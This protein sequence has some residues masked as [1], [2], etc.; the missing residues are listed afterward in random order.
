[1]IAR[2]DDALS[3]P[4]GEICSTRWST[5]RP[6]PSRTWAQTLREK[7]RPHPWATPSGSVHGC[8]VI[9]GG[10]GGGKT[11]RSRSGKR[12]AE[13]RRQQRRKRRARF[14]FGVRTDLRNRAVQAF[15]AM[16][17]LSSGYWV[18]SDPPV[19]GLCSALEF[20]ARLILGFITSRCHFAAFLLVTCSMV[21]HSC[22][23]LKKRSSRLLGFWPMILH[24]RE[25][26]QRVALIGGPEFV[27]R[28]FASACL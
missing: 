9:F 23:V 24:N 10:D 25:D 5:R 16:H 21:R 2:E 3:L 14:R 28:G 12:P 15:W 13:Q 20:G 27:C 1:M 6:I 26:T 19:V 11:R 17:R 4:P 7:P 8:G 18:F 22:I